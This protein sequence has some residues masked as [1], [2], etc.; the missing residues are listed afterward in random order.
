MATITDMSLTSS[1]LCL[2]LLASAQGDDG[3]GYDEWKCGNGCISRREKCVCG[4]TTLDISSKSWCCDPACSGA[5][6]PAGTVIPLTQACHGQCNH[7][8]EDVLRNFAGV[9]SH[10]QVDCDGV[11]RCIPEQAC[12]QWG[13]DNTVCLSRAPYL[14]AGA[15]PTCRD[16]QDTLNCWLGG[17]KTECLMYHWS[18]GHSAYQCHNGPCVINTNGQ[19]NCPRRDD[20]LKDNTVNNPDEDDDDDTEVSPDQAPDYQPCVAEYNGDDRPGV[21]CGGKCEHLGYLCHST[22]RFKHLLSEDCQTVFAVTRTNIC[23]NQTFYNNTLQYY[24]TEVPDRVLCGGAW[25]AEIVVTGE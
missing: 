9:R 2:V 18:G 17:N 11:T 23:Q 3:C 12:T 6:C 13:Y 7:H 1:L 21:T 16:G 19:Y 15:P 20:E 5:T 4:N 8:P 14:C 25:P 10:V 22:D 24:K